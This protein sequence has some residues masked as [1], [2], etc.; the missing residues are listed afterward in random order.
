M[1]SGSCDR[2]LKILQLHQNSQ[3]CFPNQN[4]KLVQTIKVYSLPVQ[5]TKLNNL[6]SWQSLPRG[7]E[8]LPDR[9]RIG[10]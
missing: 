8:S 4:H 1:D 6:M 2:Y 10:I 9:K 7:S 3:S 5:S